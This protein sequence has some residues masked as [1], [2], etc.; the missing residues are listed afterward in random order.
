M[1]ALEVTGLGKSFGSV[2][3]A[4]D[5]NIRIQTGSIVSI[6]GTNGAGKTTFINMVT[7]YVKPDH[8]RIRFAGPPASQ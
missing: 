6:I 7:G 1:P 3:A 4:K 2:A 8:G 5:L